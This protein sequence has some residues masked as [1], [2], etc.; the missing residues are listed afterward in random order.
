MSL[1][2]AVDGSREALLNSVKI[3]LRADVPLVAFCL[4]GGVDSAAIASIA[5]KEFDA[6]ITTFS[7]LTQII[8]TMKR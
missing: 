5:A 2:D 1:E 8:D 3:R 6:Q 7:L 4:S